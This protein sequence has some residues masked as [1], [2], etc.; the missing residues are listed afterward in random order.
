MKKLSLSLVA[1][2]AAAL[3]SAAAQATDYEVTVVNLTRGIHFT[4]LVVAA[5]DPAS[6]IFSAGTMASSEL[7]AVAEGGDTAS[8]TATL[9]SIGATVANGDALLAP[10]SS[11]TFS[12]SNTTAPANSVLSVVG[13]LLPTNDGFVG[14]NSQPLPTGDTGSSVSFRVFGYDAGTEA[15]DELVG[16]GAPGEAGFPAPPPTVIILHGGDYRL[17]EVGM[18]ASNALELLAEAGDNTMLT[19][20]TISSEGVYGS[21]AAD[22]A[23]GAGGSAQWTISDT[24]AHSLRSLSLATMLVNTNNGFNGTNSLDLSSFEVG[25]VLQLQTVA[26]DSG[27]EA[28]TE[29]AGTIPGPAVTGFSMHSAAAGLIQPVDCASQCS[30]IFS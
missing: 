5:H 27:T 7:Q 25:Q 21:V 11:A 29:L 18:P 14:L 16:S 2:A 24:D 8:L 12:V 17:F 20:E 22:T 9:E 6:R 10:G 3:A 1:S 23:I 19:A 30:G 28:N 26:Y 13:M 15:N 4:P